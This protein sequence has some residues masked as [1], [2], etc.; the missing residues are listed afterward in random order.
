MTETHYN[1]RHESGLVK[2]WKI[3]L[4]SPIQKGGRGGTRVRLGGGKRGIRI[5]SAE[6]QNAISWPAHVLPVY[7]HLYRL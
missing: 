3:H 5:K 2:V 6:V 7:Q 1:P 4:P